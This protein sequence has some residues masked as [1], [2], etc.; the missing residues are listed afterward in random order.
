MIRYIRV[1][2]AILTLLV[3]FS[4]SMSARSVLA[5]PGTATL[6]RCPRSEMGCEQVVLR[7]LARDRAQ[8]GLP[9]LIRAAVESRGRGVCVGSYGH[10]LAMAASG[11][12]WDTNP[13]YFRAS[14]PNNICVRSR[15]S[16]QNSGGY[17]GGSLAH[18]L[19]ALNAMMMGEP[20][21]AA[22][23]ASSTNHACDIMDPAFRY[24]GVGVYRA[25]GSTWLTEDFLG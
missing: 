17:H 5:E 20:H 3:S 19:K 2:P 12:V 7:L 22:T 1:L 13:S 11:Y 8:V 21:D 10:S 15:Y 23:C 14:F 24:V 25:H 6:A 18:D 4:M 16:G 9:P